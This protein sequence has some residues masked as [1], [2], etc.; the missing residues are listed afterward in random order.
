MV[1]QTRDQFREPKAQSK[2][3]PGGIY[4]K[5]NQNFS[6][7]FF[8]ELSWEETYPHLC[9]MKLTPAKDYG[10]FTDLGQILLFQNDLC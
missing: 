5:F 10:L 9:L 6:T 7:S 2:T 3:R 8:A 4:L 1:A